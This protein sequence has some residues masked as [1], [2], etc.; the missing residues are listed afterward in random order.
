MFN[1]PFAFN[2]FNA[3]P[4][5]QGFQ[6]FQGNPSWNQGFNTPFSGFQGANN[7]SN[8]G[9]NS[10]PWSAQS[11]W[12]N[13]PWNWN[14]PSFSN[15]NSFQG[16]SPWNQSFNQWAPTNAWN[17]FN[18]PFA[19]Q[20]P[21]PQTPFGFNWWNAEGAQSEQGTPFGFNPFTGFNPAAATQA[22]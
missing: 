3:F 8:N 16:F 14:T 10:T 22:A 9:W 11:Q 17:G 7:W 13:T 18:T 2:G 12:S 1:T 19:G 20:F 4:G 15:P 21:T 5:Q 6:G